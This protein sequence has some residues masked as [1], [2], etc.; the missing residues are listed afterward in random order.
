M[1][2]T[3]S[4][5]TILGIGSPLRRDDGI[6]IRIIQEML[7][8]KKYEGMNI[9]DGGTSPD[10]PSLLEEHLGKLII[11]DALKGGGKPGE[12]YRLEITDSRMADDIPGSVHGLGVLDGLK[13]MKILG[14]EPSEVLLIG[15]EPYDT[16]YG[17]GLSPMIE[18]AIPALI[19]AVEAE[20]GVLY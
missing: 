18:A 11:I 14:T 5:V 4:G 16:S 12:V 15:I 6:G 2:N 20:L 1:K 19:K 9:I 17:L 13:M 3:R 7:K 10:L 8:E